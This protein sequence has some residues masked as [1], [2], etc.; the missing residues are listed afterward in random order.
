MGAGGSGYAGYGGIRYRRAGMKRL[1][2]AGMAAAALA[3]VPQAS[4]AVAQV[5]G[6]TVLDTTSGKPLDDVR[7]IAFSAA[8]AGIGFGVTGG[9]GRFLFQM[10]PRGEY[11]LRA[12]KLGYATTITES[13]RVDSR[14]DIDVLLPMV[15]RPVALDTVTVVA[16][17][18]PVAQEQLPYLVDAGFYRRQ[19]WGFGYFLTRADIDQR[20]ALVMGDLLKGIP[21]IRVRCGTPLDCIVTMPAANVMFVRKGCSPSVVLD[22]VLLSPGGSSDSGPALSALKPFDLEAVEVYAHSDGAPVQWRTSP[23]GAIIAWSRR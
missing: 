4:P 17:P 18:L 7:L 2:L 16:R 5:L 12:T 11:R 6:G 1:I 19:R 15:R 21:G 8:G 13:I 20:D 9:D 14:S 3:L 23:C 10:L 22:G